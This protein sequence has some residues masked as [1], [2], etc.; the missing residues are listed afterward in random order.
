MSMPAGGG[1]Q[2]GN[3]WDSHLLSLDLALIRI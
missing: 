1:G 2:L 3:S